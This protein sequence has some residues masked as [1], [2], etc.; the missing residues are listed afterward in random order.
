MWD[1]ITPGPYIPPH[2]I[3]LKEK[4]FLT[5]Y[6]LHN[7]K[8][9]YDWLLKLTNPKLKN[10]KIWST[11]PFCVTGIFICKNRLRPNITSFD[12]EI[13]RSRFVTFIRNCFEQRNYLLWECVIILQSVL[14]S[15]VCFYDDT[16]PLL[17]FFQII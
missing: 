3:V 13:N 15:I 6:V 4:G 8:Q 10:M 5:T 11:W 7:F 9:L 14:N 1:L 12:T 16:L 17:A 2:A